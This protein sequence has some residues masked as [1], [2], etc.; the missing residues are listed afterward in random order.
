M[1]IVN[2]TKLKAGRSGVY[3]WVTV[4]VDVRE[5]LINQASWQKNMMHVKSSKGGP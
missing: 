3:V 1:A 4:D 5:L 2:E